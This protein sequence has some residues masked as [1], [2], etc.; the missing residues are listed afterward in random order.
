MMGS[1]FSIVGW[2]K[3]CTEGQPEATQSEAKGLHL[4]DPPIRAG[5]HEILGCEKSYGLGSSPRNA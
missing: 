5:V 4:M 2:Q 1:I 3:N